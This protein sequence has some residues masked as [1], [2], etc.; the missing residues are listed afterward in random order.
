MHN[1]LFI[2]FAFVITLLIMLFPACQ[3]EQITIG[4]NAKDN[5]FL[6]N[7]GASMPIKVFG[8]TSSKTFMM[9]IHGGPGGDAIVYRSDYVKQNVETKY[10]VVYWDQRNAGASQ[11]GVNGANFKLEN[12]IDDFEQVIGL[13]KQ[14]YGSDISIFVNGHSWGGYLTPAFLAT[15]NNQ[16]LV[17]GW[18]Q[19]DGAHNFPLLNQASKQMLLDKADIEIAANKN[20]A[21][22]TEIRNYCNGITLPLD[23][24]QWDAFNGIGTQAMGITTESNTSGTSPSAMQRYIDNN[25]P[26]TSIILQSIYNP[27][28]FD[29][30][31]ET[32]A[33]Y[34][35]VSNLSVIKIPT[36]LLWGKYDYICPP[37]LADDIESTIQSKYK[38]KVIFQKSSHSPMV[39]VEEPAYWEEI[40]QFI[41][42]FK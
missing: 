37:K 38:K 10:A 1:T 24:Y 13:L 25:A 41:N 20:V 3:K 6:Q 33:K 12:F 21:K 9:I 34:P 29:M 35:T 22:W 7:K 15:K 42:T 2:R 40:I 4:T 19:T 36:L 11:G 17:K 39:G 8:N 5:F 31:K 30:I 14:R 23:V 27:V 26:L 32:Y 28:T 16:D 18:I